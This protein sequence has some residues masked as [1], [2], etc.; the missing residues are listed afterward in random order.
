MKIHPATAA[1]LV[2]AAV[3]GLTAGCGHQPG[4]VGTWSG[5]MSTPAGPVST[6][7]SYT[8]DGHWTQQSHLGSVPVVSMGIYK[9]AHG[10]ITEVPETI[11]IGNTT[12]RV[13]VGLFATPA[14]AYTIVGDTLTIQSPT[15]KNSKLVFTRTQ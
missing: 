4:L 9:A 14:V 11:T 6:S 7:I 5:T 15:N 10:A 13:K 1:A 12:E 2:L 3:L 8:A